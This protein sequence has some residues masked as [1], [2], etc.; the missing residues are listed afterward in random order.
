MTLPNKILL[1][2]GAGIVA[3]SVLNLLGQAG[4]ESGAMHTLIDGYL[5]NGALEVVGRVFVASLKLLVVPLV[6]VSLVCGASS[7]GDSARMGPIAGKTL[8]FYLGTTALAVTAALLIAVPIAPGSSVELSSV[9]SFT[10]SSPPP[11]KEVLVNIFPSNP[12]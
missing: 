9:A 1:A 5:V 12:I 8:L 10:P 11:L 6:F 7:L 2:M 4:P 3:G